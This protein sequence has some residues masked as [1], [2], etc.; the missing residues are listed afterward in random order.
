MARDG[1][2]RYHCAGVDLPRSPDAGIRP[3]GPP[4]SRR[5]PGEALPP[6]KEGLVGESADKPLSSQWIAPFTNF[7]D[8]PPKLVDTCN[9]YGYMGGIGWDWEHPGST[10]TPSLFDNL[11]VAGG[12]GNCLRARDPI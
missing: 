6:S 3:T 2:V 1:L 5:F 12:A 11:P 9:I 7:G 8:E 4:P 10:F